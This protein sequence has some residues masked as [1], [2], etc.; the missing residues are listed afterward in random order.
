M[1]S[2]LDHLN[3]EINDGD[4]Y[5][6]TATYPESFEEFTKSK[7]SP[8]YLACAFAWNYERSAVVLWGTEAEKEALRQT[9]GGDA[10]KWYT[11]LTGKEPTPPGSGGSTTTKRRKKY[12]FVL[13]GRKAWRNTA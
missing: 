9:R 8:Y 5:Y 12:N 3:W 6:S 10:E 13:F 1:D 4:D 2:N 7:E 11:Y